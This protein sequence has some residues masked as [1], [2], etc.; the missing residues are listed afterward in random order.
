M[1][2]IDFVSYLVDHYHTYI[3]DIRSL[4]E[5]NSGH[6]YGAIHINT[7]IPPLNQRQYNQLYQKLNQLNIHKNSFIIVYCKKGV[8]ACIAKDILEQLGYTSV[9]NLGG[10]ETE[11]LKSYFKS[12][13]YKFVSL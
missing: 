11:P 13:I 9:Y 7:P 2:S 4:K 6:I 10:V 5:Y 12:Q 3:L 1:S 8:L